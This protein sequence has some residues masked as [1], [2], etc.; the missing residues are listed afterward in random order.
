MNTH[1]KTHTCALRVAE[2]D[3]KILDESIFNLSTIKIILGDTDQA[4]EALEY[5]LLR[6]DLSSNEK[7]DLYCNL[8]SA[9]SHNGDFIKANDAYFVTE[10]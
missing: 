6:E 7:A 5:L 2:N 1:T 8:S 10:K 4:I 3:V 9:Y